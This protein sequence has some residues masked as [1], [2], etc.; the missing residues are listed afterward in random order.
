MISPNDGVNIP[1][2]EQRALWSWQSASLPALHGGKRAWLGLVVELVV[3]VDAGK[4]TAMDVRPALPAAVFGNADGGPGAPGAREPMTWGEYSR[5]LKA[6]GL[7]RVEGPGLMLTKVGR[8]FLDTGLPEVLGAS[9]SLNFRLL[10][11]SLR[12]VSEAPVTVEDVDEY[13]R[14]AFHTDWKSLGGVRARMDW[15][16]ALGAI[17]ATAGRRWMITPVGEKMLEACHTV[18]PEALEVDSDAAEPIEPAPEDVQRML[19]ELADGTRDQASRSTYNIWVPSPASRPNKVENLRVIVNAVVDPLSRAELLEFIANTFNLR[20]SSV[21]SMLPFLRASGLILEVGFSVY[22]ASPAA[23]AWLQSGVDINFIRILHANMR[24]VGEMI[25]ATEGGATRADVYAEAERH[26]LNIDKSRWI[27]AFLQDTGL[28][29]APKYGSLRATPTGGALLAELPLATPDELTDSDAARP[30]SP[31]VSSESAPATLTGGLTTLSRTPM[32]MDQ[33][34]GKAFEQAI[35]DAFSLMGFESRTISGAGA[36]DVL[37]KWRDDSGAA[38]TAIVEAKSR[39]GGSISHTDISDVA[40]ETHKTRHRADHVA[41][42]AAAFAGDTIKTMAFTRGWTLID[43]LSLGTIAD[44]VITLG[45]AP[46]VSGVLFDADGGLDAVRAAIRDR[47]RELAV[48]AFVVGQLGVEAAESGDPITPRDISRDGR[49]T[50]VQPSVDE[51]LAALTILQDAAPGAVRLIDEN[52]DPK[53]SSFIIG[54]PRSAAS[55]LRAIA[56]AIEAPLTTTT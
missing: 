22:Q 42:I 9:L 32:A 43:A 34:S 29:M 35:S 11:E 49:R 1:L 28:V 55:S 20:R 33:G 5:F 3:Q 40:L 53:F 54:T 17:E 50:D 6:A 26:G 30:L 7:A 2:V 13:L 25:R 52:K 10:A 21:D 38:R 4:A 23:C 16:D 39:A 37:V 15:L 27:A 45:L 47:R 44:D 24:F 36:T 8:E 56:D 18:T 51:V 48:L 41:V 46:D 19:D 14:G 31:V 12:Y